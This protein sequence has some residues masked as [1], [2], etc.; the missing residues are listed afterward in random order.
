[1]VAVVVE[2]IWV[3]VRRRAVCEIDWR[4]FAKVR[5]GP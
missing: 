5:A 1:M 2:G 3:D 4:R